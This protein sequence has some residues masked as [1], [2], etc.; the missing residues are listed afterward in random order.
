MRVQNPPAITIATI[1]IGSLRIWIIATLPG[2]DSERSSLFAKAVSGF[3][4]ADYGAGFG[5]G[6]AAAGRTALLRSPPALC[7]STR[8]ISS[9]V[10]LDKLRRLMYS[11]D[12]LLVSHVA[13]A[14]SVRATVC[15][16]GVERPGRAKSP[17]N[18]TSAT[19]HPARTGSSDEFSSWG[20]PRAV[21]ANGMPD[22]RRTPVNQ[23][24]P[25]NLT[26]DPHT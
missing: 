11:L 7:P 17:A 26:P 8:H 12:V 20:S 25:A 13:F 9:L 6:T 14:E 21:T 24:D 2:A 3:G 10:K 19:P 16:G 4:A 23:E 18:P 5:N 15:G 22:D 1:W